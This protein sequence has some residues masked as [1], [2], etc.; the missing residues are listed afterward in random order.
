[1]DMNLLNKAWNMWYDTAVAPRSLH[2]NDISVL[3]ANFYAG[4]RFAL[5]AM[6]I[7]FVEWTT[8]EDAED[9]LVRLREEV[10]ETVAAVILSNP[11]MRRIAE[12]MESEGPLGRP[13]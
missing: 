1:M 6:S 12:E 8:R 11:E 10:D 9:W 13:S 7:A 4:A 2:E 5:S 3:K